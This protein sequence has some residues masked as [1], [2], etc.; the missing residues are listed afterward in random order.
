MRIVLP[1]IYRKSEADYKLNTDI[2]FNSADF[3]IDHV[4]FYRIDCIEPVK[5]IKD[6]CNINCCGVDYRIALPMK[7]VDKRV[8]KQKL[9]Y[10]AN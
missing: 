5:G 8:M 10:G 3:K 6:N 4:I 1:V 2:P 7:E 9:I